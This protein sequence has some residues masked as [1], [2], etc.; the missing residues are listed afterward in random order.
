MSQVTTQ[1]HPLVL[2]TFVL[3]LTVVLGAAAYG[4]NSVT[5][6]QPASGS[7]SSV[8]TPAPAG[9]PHAN[10]VRK[11]SAAPPQ[12]I[13][14]AKGYVATICTARGHIVLQLHPDVAP[15]TVNNFVALADRGFYDGLV[16]HRVCPGG[17]SCGPP[18]SP[19]A[20][21]QAGDP[22]GDGTG[23][24]GYSLPFE[25]PKGPY[26][27]GTVGM[28]FSNAISGSQFFINGADNSSLA[29]QSNVFN[30]FAD[31]IS[32]MDVVH[33]LQQGDRMYWVSIEVKST[34]ASPLPSPGSPPP[35]PP[36]ASPETSPSAA[37][38]SPSPS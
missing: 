10:P 1:R 3:I 22:K 25:G 37:T 28:A 18:G 38:P 15:Q 35:A 23:G 4:L 8:C 30:V 14:P 34:P 33:K 16:F 5:N 32:G 20:I 26:T 13:D 36:A 7:Q 12:T 2:A 11:Y 27:P 29:S 19:F 6:P 9:H 24:P 31:V 21:A 17:T